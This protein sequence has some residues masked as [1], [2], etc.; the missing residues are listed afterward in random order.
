MVSRRHSKALAGLAG[1]ALGAG[2]LLSGCCNKQT[3]ETHYYRGFQA[4]V[5][6]MQPEIYQKGFEEGVSDTLYSLEPEPHV[7]QATN[8][9]Y[10]ARYLTFRK[11]TPKE[12]EENVYIPV[13]VMGVLDLRGIRNLTDIN[14]INSDLAKYLFATEN[15]SAPITIFLTNEAN[16]KVMRGGEHYRFFVKNFHPSHERKIVQKELPTPNDELTTGFFLSE[17]PESLNF[18]PPFF[19]LIPTKQKKKN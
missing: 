17:N 14:E 19:E 10:V 6:A 11:R 15:P 3:A 7:R 12:A 4:G 18:Y 5:E 16:E 1:L 8:K 13:D 9:D 2:A